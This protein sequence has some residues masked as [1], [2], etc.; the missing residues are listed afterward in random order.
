M[1]QS[2]RLI[3]TMKTIQGFMAGCPK[4]KPIVPFNYEK[5]WVGKQR[6]VCLLC[7]E[8][9]I[10]PTPSKEKKKKYPNCPICGKRMYFHQRNSEFV[11]FRCSDYPEC[12]R[13]LKIKINDSQREPSQGLKLL[14]GT[15]K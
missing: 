11:R 14:E 2:K 10:F 13:Y 3:E 15:S 12:R 9:F 5:G 7:G 1:T 4:C 8:D 6:Y